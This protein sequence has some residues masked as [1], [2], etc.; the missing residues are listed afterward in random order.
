MKVYGYEV[1][2]NE[3][4]SISIMQNP[5]HYDEDIAGNASVWVMF[6]PEQI[7]RLCEDLQKVKNEMLEGRNNG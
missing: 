7:D 2:E 4:G 3:I 1:F 5:G 6:T